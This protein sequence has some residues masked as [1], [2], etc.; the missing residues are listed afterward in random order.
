MC[1]VIIWYPFFVFP[2]QLAG[3]VVFYGLDV[4]Y[5]LY[6]LYVLYVL[7]VL[8]RYVFC[9]CC[10]CVLSAMW[11]LCDSACLVCCPYVL[12]LLPNM[13]WF[14][15]VVGIVRSVCLCDTVAGAVFCCVG[16]AAVFCACCPSLDCVGWVHTW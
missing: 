3:G 6:V 9:L 16:C 10:V 8:C 13:W 2:L 12:P 14:G 5:D 7:D 4:L 1:L 15:V 11:V